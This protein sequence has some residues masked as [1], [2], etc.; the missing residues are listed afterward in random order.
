MDGIANRL[1]LEELLSSPIHY[2]YARDLVR[3]ETGGTSQEKIKRFFSHRKLEILY[4][5]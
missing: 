3:E 1:C 5:S 4:E 2:E